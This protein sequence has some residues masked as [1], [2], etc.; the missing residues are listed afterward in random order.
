MLTSANC[1][2]APDLFADVGIRAPNLPLPQQ[3]LASQ[4]GTHMAVSSQLPEVFC[5]DTLLRETRKV[6]P[7]QSIIS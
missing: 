3:P 5:G 4:P 2:K 6:K 1:P 7:D